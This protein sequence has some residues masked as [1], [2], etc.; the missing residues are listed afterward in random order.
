MMNQVTF[1]HNRVQD[2]DFRPRKGSSLIDGG[3]VIPGLNDGQDLQFNYPP[4]FPDRIESTWV[5]HQILVP[6]SMETRFIGYLDIAIP[7]LVS[8][9]SK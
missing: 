9:P 1:T 6:M 7:I 5:R 8:Y 3:K 4:S 2:Y